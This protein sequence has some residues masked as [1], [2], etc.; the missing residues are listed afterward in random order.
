MLMSRMIDTAS[1]SKPKVM[2]AAGLIE[3]MTEYR[4]K[5]LLGE[6]RERDFEVLDWVHDRWNTSMCKPAYRGHRLERFLLRA[7][8][9]SPWSIW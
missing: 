1:A 2:D 3:K 6:F 7:D 9:L 5:S 8:N 4:M